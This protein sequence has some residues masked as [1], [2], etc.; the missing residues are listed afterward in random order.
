MGWWCGDDGTHEGYLVGLVPDDAAGG[1]LGHAPG[2]LRELGSR[3]DV[4]DD[5]GRR[6]V[7]L[8]WVKVACSCGW[9]SPLIWALAGTE[10]VPSCVFAPDA[11][12]DRCAEL[13][14]VHVATTG[15]APD[16]GCSIGELL[17]LA[18]RP[19]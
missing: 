13:W 16:G 9:R 3:A 6:R 8:R 15:R 5:D 10:W 14:H 11:F 18:R 7:P 19:K 1:F 4:D 17:E 12:E 2:R